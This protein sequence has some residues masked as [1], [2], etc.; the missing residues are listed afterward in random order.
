MEK[1]FTISFSDKSLMERFER[2]LALLHFNSNFGH[3]SIFGMEMDGDGSEKIQVKDVNRDYKN[4][5]DLIGGVGY[6]I[7]LADD[8]GY[9]G[10]FVDGKSHAFYYTKD[11]SLYKDNE[12]VKSIKKLGE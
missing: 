3:S 6:Q 11:S 9:K 8:H 10:K 12:I 1:V 5:V 4:G 7:E 2:F